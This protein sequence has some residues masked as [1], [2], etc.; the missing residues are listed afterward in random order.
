[1]DCVDFD[2]LRINA[3]EKLPRGVMTFCDCG[4]DDER[5]V[6]WN[7][8]GWAELGLTPRML[9]GVEGLTTASTILG[10]TVTSP[11]MIAPSGRHALFHQQ[12]EAETARGA[13]E[14]GCVYVMS[15]SSNV[16]METVAA[17]RRQAP[18]WFQLY[19]GPDRKNTQALVERAAACGFKAIVLTL[20]QPVPGWSPRAVRDPI[21][22]A[23][24]R[25][26]NVAGAPPARSAYDEETRGKPRFPVVADDLEWLCGIS[27]VDVVVKGVMRG[28][29]ARRCVDLGAKAVIVSNHGGRHLDCVVPT[30]YALASVA[31]AVGAEAE[32][33]VDGGIRRGTDV[34]KALA[35]GA[36]AVL[37]GRPILWSLATGGGAQVAATLEHLRSDLE[38]AMALSGALTVA[39][40]TAD[41]VADRPFATRNASE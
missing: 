11:I 16:S 34:L 9:R 26:V 39:E 38:R 33:Y 37:L 8:R 27:P 15:T 30:C 32:V 28:D 31:A 3:A 29:D 1:M 21:A 41:L 40:I 17:Q 2:Q 6:S 12:G 13:T 4:A 20:D 7:E 10:G 23:V 24:D 22:G 14:A 5:T 19:C 35:L 18:Q 36:K 25:Y